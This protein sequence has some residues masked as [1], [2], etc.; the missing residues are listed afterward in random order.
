MNPTP[1]SWK[2]K[3]RSSL[4]PT[5]S[6]TQFC[7]CSIA[8]EHEVECSGLEHEEVAK[9]NSCYSTVGALKWKK[10]LLEQANKK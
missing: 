1:W 10:T 3:A 9:E 5:G 4:S 7:A 6:G 8:G 2:V